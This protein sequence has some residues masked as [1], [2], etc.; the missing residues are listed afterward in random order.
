[1]QRRP[2]RQELTMTD[3]T[4]AKITAALAPLLAA[5]MIR[6]FKVVSDRSFTVSLSVSYL[7]D[8]R[9]DLGY[10]DAT[11]AAQAAVDATA[12]ALDMTLTDA[13]FEDDGSGREW[14]SF[15]APRA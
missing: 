11:K 14:W 7:A 4:E 9:P 12:A 6:W 2:T 13:G 1:M 10:D 5:D 8:G 3:R 15:S